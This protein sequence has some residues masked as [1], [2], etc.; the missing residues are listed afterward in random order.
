[1]RNIAKV[2][3]VRRARAG[4]MRAKWRLVCRDF[5]LGIVRFPPFY[6]PI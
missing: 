4:T 6:D 1:M 2:W 3:C 5:L